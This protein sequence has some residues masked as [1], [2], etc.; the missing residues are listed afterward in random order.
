VKDEEMIK[1]YLS[2]MLTFVLFNELQLS[3]VREILVHP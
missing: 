3:E 2:I 1:R